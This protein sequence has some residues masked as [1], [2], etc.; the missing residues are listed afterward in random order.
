MQ[1]AFQEKFFYTMAVPGLLDGRPV[2]VRRWA[3][4]VTSEMGD[5]GVSVLVAAAF[6]NSSAASLPGMPF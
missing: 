2:V 3:L 5:G 4:A 1:S 6:A